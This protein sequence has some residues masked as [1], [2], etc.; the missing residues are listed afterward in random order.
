M[1]HV[2]LLMPVI[3]AGTLGLS[4]CANDVPQN[5]T[6][7]AEALLYVPTLTTT[8]PEAKQQIADGLND[9]DMNRPEPAYD[10]FQRASA[11][12]P[13]LAMAELYAALAAQAGAAPIEKAF[14]HLTRANEL[15]KNASNVERLTIQVFRKAF[16][17]DAEGALT[18]AKELVKADS[19]NPRAWNILADMQGNLRHRTEARAARDKAIAIAPEF[20]PSYVDQSA[21]YVLVEPRDLVKGEQLARKA[22]ELAP[23]DQNVYDILGDALRAQGKLEEAAQA[24]TKCA[25]LDPTKG[26]GLQQRGHVNTFLGRY[27][28]AR[29]DYDAAAGISTGN[30]KTILSMYRGF[31]HIYEGD[32][33]AAYDELQALYQSTENAAMQDADGARIVLLEQAIMPVTF[34]YHMMPQL[35]SAI[36]E[37]E[38]LYNKA[39]ERIGTEEFRRT[40]RAVTALDAGWV[41]LAKGNYAVARQQTL[42]YMKIREADHNA[43]LNRIAHDQ[44]ALI[45]FQEKNYAEAVREFEQGTPEDIYGNYYHAVA[46]DELGRHDDAQQLYQKIANWYFNSVGT[47]M[48]RKD[49]LAR[50]KKP[51]A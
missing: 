30:R 34:H 8:S 10:A 12:D 35:E 42:E 9:L 23:N 27:P 24:Y 5:E 33:K 36:A 21:S 48:V 6:V 38:A 22:V 13:Q 14:A 3:V 49:A 29:A 32:A 39:A 17:N 11:A 19:A 41:A 1:K 31:A 40:A 45:A 43:D 25:E 20:A 4:A 16:D 2:H 44:L 50:L 7:R 37:H 51:A 47:A 26:D 18:A 46:L 28:E 15:S